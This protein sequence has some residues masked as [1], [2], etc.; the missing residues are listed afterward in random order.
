MFELDH[1]N[2][3]SGFLFTNI[4]LKLTFQSTPLPLYKKQLMPKEMRIQVRVIHG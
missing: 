2:W 4:N 3:L 1:I